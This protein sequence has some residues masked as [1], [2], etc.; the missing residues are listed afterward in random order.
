MLL[1][2]KRSCKGVAY[3]KI[4]SPCNQLHYFLNAA[5]CN[6]WSSGTKSLVYI[7][8]VCTV[9]IKHVL[10]GLGILKI[11]KVYSNLLN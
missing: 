3:L 6:G 2:D 9:S 8:P 5:V 11:F 4:E 10:D 7:K 1:I